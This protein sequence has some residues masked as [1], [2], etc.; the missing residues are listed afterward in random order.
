M[1]ATN[2]HGLARVCTVVS[3]HRSL[4]IGNSGQGVKSVN[5][6]SARTRARDGV[7]VS[8]VG[9]TIKPTKGDNIEG[10][11]FSCGSGMEQPRVY[12]WCMCRDA[13]NRMQLSV[14]IENNTYPF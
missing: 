11:Q 2:L 1:F 7:A 14:D 8:G 13:S 3:E 9:L 10:A 6:R 5:G 12:D 4:G